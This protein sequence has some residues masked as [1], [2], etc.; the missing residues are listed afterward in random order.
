MMN[1]GNRGITVAS[2]D[3]KTFNEMV[4]TLPSAQS[5]F[6]PDNILIDSGSDISLVWNQDMFTCMKPCDLKQC[7]PVGST[8]LSVQAI[9]V[10]RFNLGFMWIVTVS[11]T[12]LTLKY[13]R[14]LRT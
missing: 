1:Q 14:L 10:M 13:Q 7:T 2:I 3:M 4:N 12:L 5:P 8:P 6:D 9:G 11:S